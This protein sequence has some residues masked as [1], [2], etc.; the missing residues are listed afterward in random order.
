[1]LVELPCFAAWN[2]AK[3]VD[4]A[5][6]LY[7]ALGEFEEHH[8]GT[9]LELRQELF[10]G[11]GLS[12][13]HTSKESLHVDAGGKGH[14]G[15]GDE[16]AA[17]TR[18]GLND[19]DATAADL[20]LGVGTTAVEVQAPG[21]LADDGAYLAALL[22]GEVGRLDMAKLHIVRERG[23]LLLGELQHMSLVMVVKAL[24]AVLRTID[25]LLYKD[26]ALLVYCMASVMASHT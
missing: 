12:H 17:K 3:T 7:P 20:E 9:L 19:H 1:M 18:T 21:N 26:I 23:G 16:V 24:D 14:K 25:E 10:I 6:T 5:D 11:Y 22:L 13:T 2:L 15:G 8:A 4:V